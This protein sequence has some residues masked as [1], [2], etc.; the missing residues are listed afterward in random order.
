M[1]P[2]ASAPE[3]TP[4]FEL[5]IPDGAAACGVFLEGRE[6]K[7]EY[8]LKSRILQTVAS[9]TGGRAHDDATLVVVAL[10]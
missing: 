4:T 7:T 1:V 2:R 6:L 3:P 10:A 9:F 5:S 8:E